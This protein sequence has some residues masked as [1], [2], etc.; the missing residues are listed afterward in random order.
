MLNKF[1]NLFSNLFSSRTVP[2]KLAY[3]S[4]ESVKEH[5]QDVKEPIIIMHGLFGSKNNWNSLSKAIH[6]KTKRKVILIIYE[7]QLNLDYNG[8]FLMSFNIE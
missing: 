6:Q 3:T 5:E 4:Y 2:V 1:P 8:F 7:T